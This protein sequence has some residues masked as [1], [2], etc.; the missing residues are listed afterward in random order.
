[1]RYTAMDHTCLLMTHITDTLRP[2][3]SY[4]AALNPKCHKVIQFSEK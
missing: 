2:K 1:M 3:I 4:T